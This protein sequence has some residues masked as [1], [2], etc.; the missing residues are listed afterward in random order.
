MPANRHKVFRGSVKGRLPDGGAE[1]ALMNRLI[2]IDSNRST[3]LFLKLA[4]K[5]GLASL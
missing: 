4:G 3:A 5:G 2:R 1:R